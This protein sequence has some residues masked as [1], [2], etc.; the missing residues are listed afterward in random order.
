MKLD[1]LT[2]LGDGYFS[3]H[4]EIPFRDPAREELLD[5]IIACY[6][7]GRCCNEMKG[8]RAFGT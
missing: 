6:E 8:S 2:S 3:H 4:R 7:R 1:G 5:G